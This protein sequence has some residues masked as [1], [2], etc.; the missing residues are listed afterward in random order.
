[1]PY[2]DTIYLH[3]LTDADR[4]PYFIDTNGGISKKPQ[5]SGASLSLNQHPKGWSEIEI[6]FATNQKY[7]SLNRAFAIPLTYI[8]DGAKILRHLQYKGKGFEEDVYCLILKWNDTNGRYEEEYFGKLDFLLAEDDPTTGVQVSTKEG[9]LLSYLA[10]NDSVTYELPCDETN[11]DIIKVEMDFPWLQDK[12]NYKILNL[13]TNSYIEYTIPTVFQNN[14]GDS[15]GVLRGDQNY[16]AIPNQQYYTDSENYTLLFTKPTSVPYDIDIS[17]NALPIISTIN[18]YDIEIHLKSALQDITLFAGPIPTGKNFAQT[19]SGTI[20]LA[21]NEKL[22]LSAKAFATHPVTH[23]QL[24]ASI[25]WQETSFSF[26]FE[27][28]TDTTEVYWLPPYAAWKQLVSKMTDGKYTGDSNYFKNK[29]N[30]VICGGQAL[31]KLPKAVIK[32]SVQ[33]FFEDYDCDMPMGIK[34]VNNVAWIEP[35]E[36]LY[37]DSSQIFDIG[38]LSTIKITRPDD[39][40]VNTLK[41]GSPVQ[42]YNERNGK[43][44]FNDT[45]EFKVDITAKK[46]ELNKVGKYRRDCYGMA[47]IIGDLT[48]K[49]TTDNKGDNEVFKVE[50]DDTSFTYTSK[51]SAERVESKDYAGGASIDFQTNNGLLTTT[52]NINFTYTGPSQSVFVNFVARVT[53]TAYSLANLIV[54]VNGNQVVNRQI[55]ATGGT[56]GVTVTTNLNNNDVVD[57]LITSIAGKTFTVSYA[58]AQITLAASAKTYKLKREGTVTGVPTQTVFNTGLTPKN[59][60]LAWMTYLNSLFFQQRGR[61]ITFQTGDKNKDLSRTVN[62][63]TIRESADV[64]IGTGTKNFFLPFNAVIQGRLP[65]SFSKTLKAA[66]AGHIKAN[67]NGFDLYFLPIGELKARPVQNQATEWTLLFSAQNDIETLEKLSGE[68]LVALDNNKNQL[69]YSIYNPV[70]LVYYNKMIDGKYHSK[71]LYDDWLHNRNNQY[72]VQPGYTQKW[73]TNDAPIPFQ[74]ITKNVGDLELFIYDVNARQVDVLPFAAVPDTA[75]QLPYV[76]KEVSANMATYG[77]GRYL[78]VVKSAGMPIFISEWQEVAISHPE[79]MLFNYSHSSNKMDAYFTTFKPFIRVEAYPE[80]DGT[81]TAANE[82]TDEPGNIELLNGTSYTKYILHIGKPRVGTYGIPDWMEMKLSNMFLLNN[83]SADGMQIVKPADSKLEAFKPNGY[84]LASY[85][86]A[87]RKAVNNQNL[88][89]EG[90]ALPGDEG[91]AIATIDAGAF[92]DGT[93]VITVEL[94]G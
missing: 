56:D 50:I 30:V 43:Y 22:F 24:P 63:I 77:E 38:N 12:Y 70:H 18:H 54:R 66:N 62:N 86:V 26:S 76:K 5:T 94:N 7:W 15:V 91:K 61:K 65:M 93:G 36:D 28:R 9:G 41:F 90:L 82:Y 47:F 84:P 83:V 27:T 14:E 13:L 34:V 1:M 64:Y 4:K 57:F 87:I 53:E 39:L 20:N 45:K 16:D 35:R 75:L 46:A 79:T 55:A 88:S 51:F 69:M 21:V 2:P 85:T 10:A 49:D 3:F 29:N 37:N 48:K 58:L 6:S 73:Q 42:D 32:T 89:V 68:N 31:R 8:N 23:Q 17:L 78:F 19:F 33:D 11:P 25:E 52:D 44:E 92:G 71:D 80:Y 60:L 74:I 67:Y 40:I 81:E 59:Q 72:A